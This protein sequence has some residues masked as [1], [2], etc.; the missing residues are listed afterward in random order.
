MTTVHRTPTPPTPVGADHSPLNRR[1]LLA[2]IGASGVG[3]LASR[4]VTASSP[5]TSSGAAGTAAAAESCTVTPT[6]TG[7]PFP[8]DGNSSGGGASAGGPGGST[9]GGAMGGDSA[10]F[11]VLDDPQFV[12]TDIR[13]NLDGTDT[14]DGVPFELTITVHS[15]A[16]DCAPLAGA[17][18]YIWH[19]SPDGNYS[20]YSGTMNGGDFSAVSWLRGIQVTDDA[21]QATF[22]TV[23][24]GRYS[25]RAFHIHFAVFDDAAYTNRLLTSQM[26]LPDDTIT[27]LYTEAGT[28]YA[29]ALSNVTT[30]ATD[31]IF[32][33][34]YDHQLITVA[35]DVDTG[36]TGTFTAVV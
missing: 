33:D 32:S 21:G 36:L 18:V 27:T 7:G 5:G 2:L 28:E 31:N 13:S 4:T 11:N 10:A 14:L 20:G 19:C 8:A 12:R 6:E 24:P 23:L 17:A 30:L 26:G 9:A 3:L 1:R 34:G 35:G 15:S 25:G 29:E 22:T 16:T